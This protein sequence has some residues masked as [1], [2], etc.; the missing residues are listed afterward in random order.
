MSG[1]T[2]AGNDEENVQQEIRTI[3]L[4]LPLRL[5]SVSC[6]LVSTDSGFVLIDTGSSNRRAELEKEIERAGCRPGGLKLI[7][8]ILQPQLW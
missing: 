4:P 7:L 6:Y 1:S 8:L 3:S 5:G 2:T